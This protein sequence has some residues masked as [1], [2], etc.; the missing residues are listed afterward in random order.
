MYSLLWGAYLLEVYGSVSNC[1]TTTKSEYM[2]VVEA[3]KKALW[4]IV[5]VKELRN[6]KCGVYLYCG[7]QN[8]INLTKNKVYRVRTKQVSYNHGIDFFW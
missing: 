2:V 5:L 4:L 7:N 8:V 6:Q 1:I 3:T